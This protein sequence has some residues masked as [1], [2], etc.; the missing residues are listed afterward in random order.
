MT[1]ILFLTLKHHFFCAVL[2]SFWISHNVKKYIKRA[3]YYKNWLSTYMNIFLYHS[4]NSPS[5]IVSPIP[6]I[7]ITSS[8]AFILFSCFSEPFIK[9]TMTGKKCLRLI[10]SI[11]DLSVDVLYKCWS[12]HINITYI[13]THIL[14]YET[15]RKTGVYSQPY[16]QNLCEGNIKFAPV[17]FFLEELQNEKLKEKLQWCKSVQRDMTI[18]LVQSVKFFLSLPH[19]SFSS[20]HS[21]VCD[22]DITLRVA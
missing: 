16:K 20:S 10:Y 2:F 18:K 1:P 8:L 4:F 13:R 12:Y 6:L 7:S 22:D 15:K 11:K 5:I 9:H 3:L 21:T 17:I 19:I 14:I